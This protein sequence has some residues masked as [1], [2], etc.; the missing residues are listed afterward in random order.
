MTQIQ[1]EKCLKDLEQPDVVQVCQNAI[2]LHVSLQF[3]LPMPLII[4]FVT[5]NFDF[6]FRFLRQCC[7]IAVN[8]VT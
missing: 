4:F 5:V 8:S 3:H 2:H 7:D 1:I 6:L